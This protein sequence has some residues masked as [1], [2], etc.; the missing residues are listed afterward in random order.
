MIQSFRDRR[1]GGSSL[2]KWS[3]ILRVCPA[4]DRSRF[5]AIG[6]ASTVSGSTA[7]GA[8]ASVEGMKNGV[9]VVDDYR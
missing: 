4:T 6:M 7:S 5:Q 3:G 1:P 2:V 8:S 9:E